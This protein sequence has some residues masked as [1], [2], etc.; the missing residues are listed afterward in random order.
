MAQVLVR[1]LDDK[2]VDRLKRRAKEHGRSLQSEVKTILEEAVPDYEAAW[3]RIEGFR[4]RL[5]KSGR[6]FIDSAALI[7]EDRD[8]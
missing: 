3:R 2:V 6:R 8:R 5:K 1:Q 7:R 4:K